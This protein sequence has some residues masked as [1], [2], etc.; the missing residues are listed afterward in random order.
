MTAA[1]APDELEAVQWNT[2]AFP[3]WQQSVTKTQQ[4]PSLQPHVNIEE[5]YCWAFYCFYFKGKYFV[6]TGTLIMSLRLEEVSKWSA[7]G[8]QTQIY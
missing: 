1:E 3:M 6:L 4:E 7:C 2:E 5:Q 8:T